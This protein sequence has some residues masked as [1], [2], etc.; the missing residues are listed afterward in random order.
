MKLSEQGKL[1]IQ[2]QEALRLEAYA[3]AIGIPTIGW[4]HTIGVKLGDVCTLE[5]AQRYFDED[6]APVEE[7]VEKLVTVEITQ[8]QFDALCSFT[9][10]LGCTSLRNSTLLRKLNA[11]DKEGA[12][13]EFS[14]WNHAGGKELAGL[15]KRRDQEK[16]MFLA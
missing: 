4:G 9:F 2:A 5:Q 16:Q 11:D 7:C 6:I 14:R 1:F 13:A 10:N 12:A 8:E 3:D 15:T